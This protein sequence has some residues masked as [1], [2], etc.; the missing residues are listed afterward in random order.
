[1]ETNFFKTIAALCPQ[2]DL[3]MTMQIQKNGVM[4]VSLL[5]A[6]DSVDD[7][8]AWTIPPMN[9]K[10]TAAEMDQGFFAAIENPL[11]QTASLLTNMA[12]YAE[13]LEEAR[14]KSKMEKENEEKEKKEVEEKHKKFQAQMK[15]VLE[16]EEKEK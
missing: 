5:L 6:A 10:G 14:K 4:R 11:K 12:L 3:K 15:K 1:M 13:A 2:G 16:L 8:A 9:L 7:E